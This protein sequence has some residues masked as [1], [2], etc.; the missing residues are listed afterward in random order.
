M[1]VTMTINNFYFYLMFTEIKFPEIV[2]F[3]ALVQGDCHQDPS[4][5]NHKQVIPFSTPE[6]VILCR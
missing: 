2:T 1:G 3:L 5:V 6:A 4:I